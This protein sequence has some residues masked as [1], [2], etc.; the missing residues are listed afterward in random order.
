MNTHRVYKTGGAP[1]QRRRLPSASTAWRAAAPPPAGPFSLVLAQR[2]DA[3][4]KAVGQVAPGH[5]LKVGVGLANLLG[6]GLLDLAI[7]AHHR[8]QVDRLAL[9]RIQSKRSLAGRAVVS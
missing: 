9:D 6:S 2:V 4:A 7:T 5:A 8:L 1:Q 3:V